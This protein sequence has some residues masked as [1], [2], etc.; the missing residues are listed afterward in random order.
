MK[1][2]LITTYYKD[3]VKERDDELLTSIR[4][5]IS[6]KEIDRVIIV[7]ERDTVIPF[8]HKKIVWKRQDDRPTYNDFFNIANG[9]N[10]GLN[11]IANTDISFD[12]YNIRLIGVSLRENQCYALSRW[13]TQISGDYVHYAQRDSQDTWIFSGKIKNIKGDFLIGKPG[14]DNRIA[15]EIAEAGYEVLN[16]SKTIQSNHLHITGIRNYRRVEAETVPKPYKFLPPVYLGERQRTNIN[17]NEYGEEVK[18]PIEYRESSLTEFSYDK[19]KKAMDNMLQEGNI[20]KKYLLSICIPSLR[21]REK[22]YKRLCAELHRQISKY[23]LSSKVEIIDLIDNGYAPI[24]WKRNKLNIDA[25]GHYV[26][27][28]D[29]DDIVS[30]DYLYLIVSA[31]ENNYG[32]DVIT[33]N[34]HVTIEEGNPEMM[35]FNRKYTKN[36]QIN[37]EGILF[38]ERAPCHLNAIRRECALEHP[39]IIIQK[40][41]AKNRSQRSDSGSDVHYSLDMVR[42]NTLKTD[43]HIDK[44]LYYYLYKHKH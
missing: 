13:D 36:L 15:H 22:L 34:G 12:E 18:V 10:H 21:S 14:C 3:R 11:I 33:F 9:N 37:N 17:I 20:P 2:T 44:V 38:S 4:I 19:Q 8:N 27:H 16:P 42:D 28:I 41:G 35:Y 23:K 6:N 30:E 40:K 1:T 29:D 26:A 43:Y 31:I 32:V 25:K 39:F 7:I 5:N 24:G